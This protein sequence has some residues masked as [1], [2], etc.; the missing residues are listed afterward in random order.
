MVAAVLMVVLGGCSGSDEFDPPEGPLSS[1]S[2]TP[3][4]LDASSRAGG[5]AGPAGGEA[6]PGAVSAPV[7]ASAAALPALPLRPPPAD[8][9]PAGPGLD[10]V[11]VGPGPDR[12][13]SG[14]RSRI[15]KPSGPGGGRTAGPGP[16]T[17]KPVRPA[18]TVTAP[19]PTTSPSPSVEPRRRPGW[20]QDLLI[21]TPGWGCGGGKPGGSDEIY[22]VQ[23]LQAAQVCLN[24]AKRR[25]PVFRLR[26]PSGVET[27]LPGF[28]GGSMSGWEWP[29]RP[30]A[31]GSPLTE[32]GIHRF[33]VVGEVDTGTE[34]A[35]G[36]AIVETRGEIIVV[37]SREPRTAFSVGAAIGAPGAFR[38]GG[39][40]GVFP[41]GAAVAIRAAGYRPGSRVLVTVY[42]DRGVSPGFEVL[43]DLPD[44]VVDGRG[45]GEIRWTLPRQPRS[46]GIWVEPEP[47]EPERLNNGLTWYFGVRG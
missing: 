24:Y 19:V 11:P 4:P 17:G 8:R 46:Y 45:E 40:A 3:H 44:L 43:T 14:P 20:L 34:E 10:R 9:L 18:P 22:V 32:S 38:P 35:P 30:G 7:T 23:R 33:E 2:V 16:R 27:R 12:L 28:Y 42:R 21:S 25:E 41:P 1:V 6:G 29:V 37:P 13:P 36:A 15:E 47:V 39:A 5:E 26:S 31:P